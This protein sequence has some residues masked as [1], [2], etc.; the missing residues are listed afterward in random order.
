M[1][2]R[3]EAWAVPCG[4]E[5]SCVI[6]CLCHSFR[7]H[8]IIKATSSTVANLASDLPRTFLA[9]THVPSIQRSCVVLWLATRAILGFIAWVAFTVDLPGYA[10][11]FLVAWVARLAKS[12]RP[13]HRVSLRLM[14]CQDFEPSIFWPNTYCHSHAKTSKCTGVPKAKI[15]S[16]ASKVIVAVQ[17][18]ILLV[19]T[20]LKSQIIICGPLLAGP[21]QVHV[22]ISITI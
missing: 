2:L 6:P 18:P 14:S 4:C 7:C 3:A 8:I 22:T 12:G 16:Q 17:G 19:L 5:C 20:G 9:A 15:G 13:K 10:S 21:H 11:A 1:S